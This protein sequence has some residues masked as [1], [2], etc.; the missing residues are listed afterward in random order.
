MIRYGATADT[1]PFAQTT[2][3]RAVAR[4]T[5]TYSTSGEGRRH[6]A[7]CA[8]NAGATA[9]TPT[10]SPTHH[11]NHLSTAVAPFAS[12]KR[13][14]KTAPTAGPTITPAHTSTI[15]PRTSRRAGTVA[16]ARNSDAP[17]SGSTVF[18]T[19]PHIPVVHDVPLSTSAL[20]SAS[21]TAASSH[22]HEARGDRTRTA[23]VTPAPGQNA[24][25][26]VGS[27]CHIIDARAKYTTASA[28]ACTAGQCLARSRKIF[29]AHVPPS[30]PRSLSPAVSRHRALECGP[31]HRAD[32]PLRSAE[33]RLDPR[34]PDGGAGRLPACELWSD[35]V[36]GRGQFC[37]RSW[38]GRGVVGGRWGGPSRGRPSPSSS[39]PRAAPRT[40]ARTR[41]FARWVRW[42]CV[43]DG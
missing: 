12:T 13:P 34:K 10:A 7:R 26:Q 17:T 23:N 31:S 32:G 39:G 21:A 29:T 22:G 2:T 19:A 16:T 30:G 1:A 5:K 40:D 11:R 42:V 4:S 36:R 18:A 37:A 24:L 35:S 41:W 38:L 28:R 9:A 14:P 15:K 8:S 3:P 33:G 27:I 6:I 25:P 20:S 43:G